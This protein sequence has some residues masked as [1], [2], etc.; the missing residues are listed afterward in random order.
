VNVIAPTQDGKSLTIAAATVIVAT[1]TPERFTIT[2]P[3]EKKA[4]IIMSHVRELA[5]QHPIIYSQLELDKSDTLDRLKRERSKKHITFKRGGGIQ[6]LTLDAR[7]SKKNI[8]AAMG[9]GSKNIIADEAGLVEDVLW[10]TVMRMLGGDKK[11]SK[12][13]KILIKIGNP[14]Y[15]NHFYKSSKSKRY[16]QI[17]HNYKDSIRDY[18]TGY[19][20]FT[21]DYMDEMMEE[22]MFDIL[23]ECKFPDEDMVDVKGYRQLITEDQLVAVLMKPGKI[24]GKPKLGND[25]G[26]GGDLNTYIKRWNN[27]ATISGW[28]KSSDTMI[29]VTEIQKEK[30][31]DPELDDENIFIDAIGLGQGVVDRCHE[32]EMAVTAVVAGESAVSPDKYINVKAENYWLLRNDIVKRRILL[33]PKFEK[34]W[35]QLLWIKYKINSDRQI[36]IEPKEDLKKRTGKSPDFIEGLMLTYTPVPFIGFV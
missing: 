19:Y 35:R 26:G 13:K 31:K 28:N 21:Q 14:F 22:A 33:D 29:N 34:Q 6:T 20:G 8:E 16:L 18:L 12:Q 9:F 7:N 17:F 3:S 5:T 23:Y 1:S 4:D 30:E 32:K 11:G 24:I 25:V 2:A 27:Y 36:K 15:R 10:A